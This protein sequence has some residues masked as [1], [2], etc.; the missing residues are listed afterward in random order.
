MVLKIHQNLYNYLNELLIV[1]LLMT[2]SGCRKIFLVFL[3]LS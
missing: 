2:K 3:N 1:Y